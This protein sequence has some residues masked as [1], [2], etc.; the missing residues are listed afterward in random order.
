MASESYY[1]IG[2]GLLGESV[3]GRDLGEE[4][5]IVAAAARAGASPD[6]VAQP[7]FRFS[8]MGPKGSNKQLSE[9]NRNKLSRRWPCPLA[10][11]GQ[12]PAGFT[13]L[14]QFIDH[15]L[16]S[17]KT[18]VMLGDGHLAADLLQGAPQPRP[19]LALRRRSGRPG[20]GQVLR[21]GRHP[22]EGGED[23]LEARQRSASTFRGAQ[24]PRRKKRKAI[25]PDPR[26]D[27]NL[28]VAQT[29]CAMIRFHNRVVD[30][31]SASSQP[32]QKFAKR[33]RS[34][35]S[36][37]SG[38]SAR[39]TCRG[40]AKPGVVN[41]VFNNGRKAFEAG[42]SPTT[43]RRCPSS[44]RWRRSALA[45]RWSA[46]RYNWNAV[47]DDGAGTLEFLFDFSALGGDLGGDT[48]LRASG[49]PTSGGFTT[50]AR[51][52][53]RTWRCRR[54]NSIARCGSTPPSSTHCS[55]SRERSDSRP[56]PA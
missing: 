1:V 31:Q 18:T 5:P 6:S 45:T 22:P 9:A 48:R 19:R 7:P 40:S 30:T 24:A 49:S 54:R 34:S 35:R 14:G 53:S 39:T 16:T 3:G 8:R 42:A 29:H 32:A 51:R 25:I 27:E 46:P 47:F 50:S 41:D 52:T 33:A 11:Q 55:T 15:D 17:D 43:F 10:A 26:N 12:I 21:G 36:T 20:V 28:A 13:Y 44:S 4:P 38:W 56:A 23:H 37:T 2:E